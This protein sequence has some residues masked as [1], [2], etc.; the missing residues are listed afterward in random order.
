MEGRK[1]EGGMG[2]RTEEMMWKEGRGVEERMDGVMKEGWREGRGRNGGK[3]GGNDVEGG[4]RG[5]GKDG[6]SDEG[7]MEERKE[8]GGMGERTEE[9]MWTEG[10]GWRGRRGM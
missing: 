3:D 4:E 2:E 6:W 1:E 9:M 10:R 5:G 7:R 8:E